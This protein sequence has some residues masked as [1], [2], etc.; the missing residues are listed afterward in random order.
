MRVRV[1]GQVGFPEYQSRFVIRLQNNVSL[2]F[3]FSIHD[4]EGGRD[5][6]EVDDEANHQIAVASGR[7]NL[8]SGSVSIAESPLMLSS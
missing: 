6:D 4:N 2:S 7:S 1:D 3:L 8:N 5:D